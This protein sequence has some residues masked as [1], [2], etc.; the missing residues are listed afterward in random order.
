M[1]IGNSVRSIGEYAFY[2]CSGLTSSTIPDSVTKL[3]TN[4]FSYCASLTNIVIGA[5]VT[6]IGDY[7]FYYCG[8]L[9][10]AT[11]GSSVTNLGDYAF[12]GCSLTRMLFRGNAP[13]VN[14]MTFSGSP[15]V[16][17]IVGASGWTWFA[18]LS[19]VGINPQTT[20]TRASANQLSLRFTGVPQFPYTLVSA[21]NFLPPIH[22]QPVLTSLADSNGNWGITVTNTTATSR[23]FYR[24]LGQ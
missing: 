4:A 23:C 9:G 10:S 19:T 2:Y 20:I 17:Y 8:H 3:G 22:W 21:T 18:G 16:Y 13:V 12:F 7:T 5:G 14:Y 1:L 24:V 15:T 11:I 6:S